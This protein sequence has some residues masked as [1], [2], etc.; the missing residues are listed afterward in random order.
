LKAK[1]SLVSVLVFIDEIS[2]TLDSLAVIFF[3]NRA[4]MGQLEFLNKSD[5]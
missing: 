3:K 4:G 5:L 1:I 2:F